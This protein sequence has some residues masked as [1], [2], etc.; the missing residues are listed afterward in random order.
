MLIW[1]SWLVE[2]LQRK[3]PKVLGI[4]GSANKVGVGI[5]DET[6]AVLSNP[7][8]TCVMSTSS[9]LADMAAI[10]MTRAIMQVHHA[11][12]DRIPSTRNCCASSA[13]RGVNCQ[14]GV[15]RSRPHSE[16]HRCNSLHKGMLHVIAHSRWSSFLLY[17]WYRNKRTLAIDSDF[18]LPLSSAPGEAHIL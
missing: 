10:P 1:T 12:R 8:K 2:S 9:A 4:E 16:R 18:I 17:P 3:M 13:T 6:G 5:V 15:G 11:S 7:R 14:A